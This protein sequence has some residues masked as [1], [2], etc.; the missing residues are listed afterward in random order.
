M[1]VSE[2]PTAYLSKLLNYTNIFDDPTIS[3]PLVGC[4]VFMFE[5]CCVVL[6]LKFGQTLMEP[7]Q[8]AGWGGPIFNI[9][10]VATTISA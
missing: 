1:W 8:M 10:G 7:V 4:C 9:A 2:L 5:R 6:V 3:R